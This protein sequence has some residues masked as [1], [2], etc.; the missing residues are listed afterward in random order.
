MPPQSNHHGVPASGEDNALALAH[1][2]D[3]HALPQV[4]GAGEQERGAQRDDPQAAGRPG[5]EAPA[6]P[7]SAAPRP[8]WHKTA[9]SRPGSRGWTYRGPRRAAGRSPPPGRG[10]PA[11]AR[12]PP[13]PG[14]RPPQ[15]AQGPGARMA[16]AGNEHHRHQPQAGQIG[17]GRVQ[18]EISRSKTPAAAR[19]AGATPAL[20]ASTPAVSRSIGPRKRRRVSPGGG[21]GPKASR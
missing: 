16:P 15:A 13:R 12:P 8:A 4:T 9:A 18:G 21:Q 3:V 7:P 10:C 2:Q 14:P 1:V 20:T 11:A 5:P 19:R 6:A 17:Q